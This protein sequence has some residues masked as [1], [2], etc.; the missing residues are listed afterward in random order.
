MKKANLL[1]VRLM[2]A[3]TAVLF[4]VSSCKKDDDGDGQ[5][6]DPAADY[7]TGV[8]IT[9]EGPFQNGTGTISHIDRTSGAA[10]NDLFKTVNG[11][12]LGN[13]V[14]SATKIGDKTY[15]VVNNA[16]KIEV[17]NSKTFKSEA[18]IEGLEL[19]RYIVVS[20]GKGYVSQT[21]SFGGNGK[22]A[23]VDL[24]TNKVTKNI[25]VGIQPEQMEVVGDFLVVINAGANDISIINTK[26]DVITELS[27]EV[28]DR[29]N[30]I[31]TD[32]TKVWVLCG[33]APSWSGTATAGSL[34]SFD[35]TNIANAQSTAFLSADNHPSQLIK[36]GAN[37]LYYS[38]KGSLYKHA[39][40]ATELDTTTVLLNKSF[41]NIG[42]DKSNNVLYGAD[43][44]D[45]SS[46]GY[47]YRYNFPG[48]SK[49][50]SIKVGIIPGNF[51][52]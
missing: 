31:I 26:T 44:V 9:N 38:Y 15:I 46:N 48:F 1:N 51:L 50:D 23:V 8:L 33:G 45:F 47:I 3:L 40:G 7:S 12:S 34:V 27:V 22:I 30:S 49:K 52:F 2:A 17:V 35:I 25:E 16:N 41:Y 39:A 42:F 29:P 28:G 10:T 19:P 24:A 6:G 14:Q 43:A 36:D 5:G 13:I 21:V 4:L 32:G 20:N 18:V 11:R 37:N